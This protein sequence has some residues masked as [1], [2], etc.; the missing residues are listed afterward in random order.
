MK[1]DGCSYILPMNKIKVTSISNVL[2]SFYF[3]TLVCI[4]GLFIN[5]TTHGALA[6]HVVSYNPEKQ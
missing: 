1:S 4:V 5:K 2:R 3:K 6:A